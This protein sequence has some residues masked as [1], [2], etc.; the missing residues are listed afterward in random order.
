MV[1]EHFRC[2]MSGLRRS[3]NKIICHRGRKILKSK[4]ENLFSEL[5]AL[6]DNDEDDSMFGILSVYRRSTLHTSHSAELDN[7]TKTTTSQIQDKDISTPTQRKS[8][9]RDQPRAIDMLYHKMLRNLSSGDDPKRKYSPIKLI[10]SGTFGHVILAKTK[11]NGCMVA[12]KILEVKKQPF[13]V[14]AN[15]VTIMKKIYHDNVVTA[16]DAIYV[17]AVKKFWLVMEYVNGCSLKKIVRNVALEE[18]HIC[19][20]SSQCVKGLDYLHKESIVHR[21]IKS[22]NVL[23]D[24]YGRVKITD[25]GTSYIYDKNAKKNEIVGSPCYMAP[26]VVARYI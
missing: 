26:E 12:I 25:F 5:P 1:E 21:D 22:S 3:N 9:S 17:E 11:Q 20:I 4:T 24:I 16:L 15:E 8:K 18:G 6:Y 7:E 14:L 10:D 23:V 19:F 2:F 13:T